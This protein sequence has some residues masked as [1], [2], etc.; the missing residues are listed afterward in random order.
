MYTIYVNDWNMSCLWMHF[1]NV[2]AFWN[3]TLQWYNIVFYS[4]DGL[5]KTEYA[6]K[7]LDL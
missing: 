6:V 7:Y 2:E 4:N 3:K 1:I 5:F